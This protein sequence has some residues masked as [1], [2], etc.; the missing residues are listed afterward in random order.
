MGETERERVVTGYITVVQEGRFRFVTDDG[1]GL[2]LTLARDAGVTS[3]ELQQL[4]KAHTRARIEYSGDSNTISGLAHKVERF[5]A[6]R[7]ERNQ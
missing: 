3:S 2:L 6:N 1:R 5:Q 7:N 4:Q